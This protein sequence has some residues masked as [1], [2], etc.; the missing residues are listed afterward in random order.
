MG[1]YKLGVL[2]TGFHS[3]IIVNAWKNGLLEEYE[4][5]GV[6]GRNPETRA[7]LAE[8]AGCQ[9]CGSVEELLALKPDYI[10][11]AA[12]IQ[13][14]R[15]SAQQIL[16]SGCSLVLI[17]I[18][19]FADED[20]YEKIRR[21]AA[22]HGT[23]VYLASGCIGGFD[24]LRTMSL[25]GC[26]GA[27]IET[28]KGPASL[29]GTPLFQEELMAEGGE[30]K[31]FS[32]NAAEAIALLP[33]KVNVAVAASLATRGPKQTGVG[34]YSVP[35]YVGDDHCITAEADGVK[36]VVDVYSST[37]AVAAWSEVAVLRNIVSPIVFG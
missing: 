13:L 27:G 8:S 9:A 36:A 15:D 34:I 37:S 29:R 25:M 1:K 35:G 2:G 32:G 33:T 20:F 3:E 12:S 30:T 21:T 17:S 31:V 26:T 4:L 6:M 5:V 22:E 10:A 24:I 14:V 7:A 23:R 19:A 16:S 28:H 18:G 11:E